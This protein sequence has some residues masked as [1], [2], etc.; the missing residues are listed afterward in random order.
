MADIFD[1]S[2]T[3]DFITGDLL[4]SAETSAGGVIRPLYD[5]EVLNVQ[6][7]PVRGSGSGAQQ[8]IYSAPTIGAA[9]DITVSLGDDDGAT[10]FTTGNS[11]ALTGGAGITL[12]ELYDGSA[13]DNEVVKLTFSQPMIGGLYMLEHSTNRSAS[14]AHDAA[15]ATVQAALEGLASI[16][17]GNVSVTGDH[18][19]GFIIEFIGTKAATDMTAITGAADALLLPSG[20]EGELDLTAA[21]GHTFVSGEV[22]TF[23]HVNYDISGQ[24]RQFR[25]PVTFRNA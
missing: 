12:L 11:F 8:W 7:Y 15:A 17:S 13:S 23:I 25:W 10:Q 5:T 1:L 6:L 21:T 20:H 24:V 4:A 3:F 18:L 2:L 16:G 14:I 9:T 22:D 19:A